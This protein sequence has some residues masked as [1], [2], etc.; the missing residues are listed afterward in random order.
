M[1]ENHG[2][3]ILVVD[4]DSDLVESYR[5]VFEMAGYDVSTAQSGDAALGLARTQRP[6]VVLTDVSMAN[7]DGFELIQRLKTEFG[8]ET[9]PVVVCSAFDMTEQEAMARG[10][11]SFLQKP[12]SASAL[13]RSIEAVRA[14][15][16]LE[17]GAMSAER[18]NVT[19]ERNRQ[20][21]G[22]ELRLRDL[23]HAEVAAE[24]HP[25]L[26]WFR[27]YFDCGSAGVFLLEGG[28]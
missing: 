21:R 16:N 20:M 15:K 6:D 19:Q 14:G 22:S 5:Q 13:V 28:A 25:W 3:R 27:R 23:D 26:E 1:T 7:M 18:V 11:G 17:N 4:D 12:A 24:A 10:A 8:G 9:P 2:G